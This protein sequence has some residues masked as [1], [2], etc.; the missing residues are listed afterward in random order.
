LK[1]APVLNYNEGKDLFSH[2]FIGEDDVPSSA[3][4]T[5]SFPAPE[6]DPSVLNWMAANGGMIFPIAYQLLI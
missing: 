4:Q 5:L 6:S 3:G 1:Q 2:Y